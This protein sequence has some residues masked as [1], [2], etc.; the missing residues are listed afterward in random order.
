[1]GEG[2]TL[3]SIIPLDHRYILSIIRSL[4]VI[5]NQFVSWV[6][7]LY[8]K[9]E[10]KN[11]KYFSYIKILNHKPNRERNPNQMEAVHPPNP[12]R[13]VSSASAAVRRRL[14]Q[15]DEATDA[16]ATDGRR[17]RRY[18]LLRRI[19]LPQSR[20]FLPPPVFFSS[21]HPPFGS[22]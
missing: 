10:I 11:T 18:G 19:L 8:P 6:K 13:G 1:M 16:A 3:A 9:N 2:L 17:R 12:W 21:S 20:V 4:V 22:S 7:K 15:L 5:R 14:R